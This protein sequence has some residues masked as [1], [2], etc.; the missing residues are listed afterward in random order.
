VCL[1]FYF[2]VCLCTCIPVFLHIVSDRTVCSLNS[3]FFSFPFSCFSPI[4]I[5]SSFP[6]LLLDLPLA[7]RSCFYSL[8][9]PLPLTEAA[10]PSRQAS[11]MRCSISRCFCFSI[12]GTLALSLSISLSSWVKPE[13]GALPV[14]VCVC[15][16]VCVRVCVC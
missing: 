14:C 2:F 15:V 4:T 6:T 1:S 7:H 13:V 8:T 3:V 10:A 9:P 5:L 16:C 11:R 12:T